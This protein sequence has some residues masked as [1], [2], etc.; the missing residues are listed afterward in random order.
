MATLL[1]GFETLKDLAAKRVTEVG[2]RVVN[3]AIAATVAEHN[4]QMAA[5][6]AVLAVPTTDFKAR[7]RTPAAAR[8]QPLD[9]SGR[10]LPIKAPGQYDVAFPIQAGGAVWGTTFVAAQ[11]MTVQEA[12]DATFTLISA[13]I[14]WLR[15]HLLAAL[16]DDT[17]WTF[18]DEEKGSLGV[19][20][21]ANGDTDEYLVLT[22]GDSGSID[23]HFL[24][25]AAAIDSA[26]N[27][28]P[29]IYDEISEHPENGGEV[30]SMVPTNLLST[31]EALPTFK[32]IRDP[33]VVTGS[34]TDILIGE[35][36]TPMPGK[37][38]G[39]VDKVWIVEWRSLPD[40]YMIGFSTDG[41][42]ALRMREHPE[43][44]LRGFI[45]A[46]TIGEHPFSGSQWE[47]H[48]GF[49][50]WNRVGAVVYQIGAASYS[51]PTGYGIPMP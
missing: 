35:L 19:K 13:D 45:K 31:V 22:G 34:G 46:G 50:A 18:T 29:T 3:E 14:R 42:P 48:A 1:Y 43:A 37:L 2:V 9:E 32:P 38:V 51:V 20:G 16:F 47:R 17:G 39:Y 12:N 27:P 10:A 4:R 40:N 44:G 33:N 11:K 24:A 7:F 5:L 26:N 8:L 6:Q 49:G 36:G 25:Q 21:P 15:D 41:E 28:F 30:V 23:D